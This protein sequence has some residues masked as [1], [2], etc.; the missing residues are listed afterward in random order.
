MLDML[1]YI[2]AEMKMGNIV[3]FPAAIFDQIGTL[4]AVARG[5]VDVSTLDKSGR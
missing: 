2:H 4:I 1:N 3:I 5:D